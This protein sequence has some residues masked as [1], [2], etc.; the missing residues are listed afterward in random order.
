MISMLK[1]LYIDNYLFRWNRN[2]G[3]YISLSYKKG[4]G[5]LFGSF[6]GYRVPGDIGL[7]KCDPVI[8]KDVSTNEDYAYSVGGQ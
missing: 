6:I 8:E 1:W 4:Q 3:Y 2:H 7:V 5:L